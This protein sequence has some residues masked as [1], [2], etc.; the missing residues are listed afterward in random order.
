MIVVA[1]VIGLQA[2]GV[3]LISAMLIMPPAA[4]RFWTEKLHVMV[5]LSA[6]IGACKRRVGRDFFSIGA[7]YADRPADCAGR[8]DDVCHFAAFCARS[9]ALWRGSCATLATRRLVRRE[10]MLRDLYEMA[11]EPPASEL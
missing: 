10:N 2:V 4:A 8:H 7:A 9:A 5:P 11:E 6:L 1:V 3:V